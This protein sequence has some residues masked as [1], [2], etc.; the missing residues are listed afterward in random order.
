MSRGLG[1][2]EA[3]ERVDTLRRRV[4][5]RLTPAGWK[6]RSVAGP[7]ENGATATEAVRRMQRSYIENRAATLRTGHLTGWPEP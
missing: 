4:D 6:R 3:A 2:N 5:S 7:L 1:E